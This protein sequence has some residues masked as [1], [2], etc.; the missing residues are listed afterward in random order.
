[1]LDSYWNS[2]P[3]GPIT[4][5][6]H[7][8][9]C[10][11]V[12]LL[13]IGEGSWVWDGPMHPAFASCVFAIRPTGDHVHVDVHA[14]PMPCPCP[15]SLPTRR[16][17]RTHVHV[18]RESRALAIVAPIQSAPKLDVELSLKPRFGADQASRYLSAHYTYSVSHGSKADRRIC[19][20]L[21][22]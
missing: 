20:L 13:L 3:H 9:K 7:W 10:E 19:L 16:T 4:C 12:T 15:C 17:L 22:V 2:V 8:Y 1:M 21:R 18:P 6:T 14:H 11:D 5:T